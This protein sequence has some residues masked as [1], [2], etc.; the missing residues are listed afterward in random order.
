V[1]QILLVRH[2]QSANN[3]LP[4]PQR[5][6]DP[7]LTSLGRRQAEK[8]A[9]WFASNPPSR[10]YCSGFLRALETTAAIARR[11]RIKPLVHWELFEQGGCYSG[12]KR[13]NKA[14]SP[15]MGRN[16]IRSLFGDWEIDDRISEKGWYHGRKLESDEDA[17]FRAQRIAR[18]IVDELVP[19]NGKLSEPGRIAFVIH[20]DF[21]MLLIE[22]MLDQF[23]LSNGL[24][25]NVDR[26]QEPWNTSIS[27]LTWQDG[28][29][30]LDLWNAVPHLQK[31]DLSW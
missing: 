8:L 19:K 28:G 9:E 21:K 20:A 24:R 5:V 10:L 30:K 25:Q 18:W 23:P 17:I 6:P 14:P 2:G 31:D 12:Y 7:A 27:Q 3:A 1:F 11:L 4:E 26:Y 15:G 13:T 22:A 16:Q 29:W